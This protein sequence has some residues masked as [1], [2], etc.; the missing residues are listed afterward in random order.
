[1][2]WGRQSSLNPSWYGKNKAATVKSMAELVATQRSDG[3]WGDIPSMPSGPY[4]TGLALYALREAGMK[5]SDP[6][7]KRGVQYLLNTQT[8]DGSWYAPSR[9]IPYNRTLMPDSRTRRTS[10]SRSLQQISRSW[11]LVTAREHL[12]HNLPAR[13][14][15]LLDRRRSLELRD[16]SRAAGDALE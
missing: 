3:G 13:V 12:R 2:C 6:V 1:M 11:R 4:A 15:E 8:E 7:Y 14:S 10:G 9:S 5:A 16:G